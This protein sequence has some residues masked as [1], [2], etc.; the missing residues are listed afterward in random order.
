MRVGVC[1]ASRGVVHSRTIESVFNNLKDVVCDW[2]L[3]FTHDLS[4]PDA[5]NDLI[6][7][8]LLWG[9]EYFW[10]VEEDMLIPDGT[11]K[12]MVNAHE[13]IVAVDYPVGGRQYSTIAVKKDEILWCGLGCTLIR[14]D[15]F[16]SIGKPFFRTDISVKITD[17]EKFEYE[18]DKSTPY[19]YGGHDILF[20]IQARE[21]GFKIHRVPG[22]ICG[23]M[24][25]E[26]LGQKESNTGFHRV[27]IMDKIK[28]YQYY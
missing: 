20:G 10:F 4:I 11:F 12:E 1:I 6:V 7:R 14:K 9:A 21:R 8:A 25:I 18:I 28:N 22:I 13:A 5:Q 16:E 26:N 27:K 17:K 23:H 19:K 24:R 2:E 3:F 15:V